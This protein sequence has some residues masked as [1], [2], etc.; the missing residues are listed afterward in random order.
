MN[1]VLVANSP[2]PFA[3]PKLSLRE[4][5]ESGSN[6]IGELLGT[7]LLLQFARQLVLSGWKF[8][9]ISLSDP[10]A[11]DVP[12]NDAE[13]FRQMARHA[14]ETNT[15]KAFSDYLYALDLA[16]KS[17]ELKSPGKFPVT[18]RRAGRIEAP[19]NEIA[20]LNDELN[21]ALSEAWRAT[22]GGL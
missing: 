18:I 15:V 9:D 4:S 21:A 13:Q 19:R 3:V 7:Q 22:Q 10:Y 16:P 8:R 2:K 20:K 14:V 12:D 11:Q 17:I 1:Q 6:A 5:I